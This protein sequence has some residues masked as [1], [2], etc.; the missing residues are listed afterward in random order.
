MNELPPT[1]TLRAFEAAARHSTFTAASA[2]LNVTQSAVSHQILYLEELWGM[3]LF[4]RGR[5]LKLTTEGDALAPIIRQFLVSLDATLAGLRRQRD[6]HPLRISLT[7]SF[8]SRWP[9]PRLPSIEASQPN[10]Q[11]WIET[12]D[13]P[14]GFGQGDADIA[15]RLGTGQYP[16]LFAELLLREYIFPVASKQLLD[17]LGMPNIPADLLHYPLLFRAGPDLV[18]KWEYWFERAGVDVSLAHS[19]TFYPD[20]N[21]TIEAALAGYGIALVRSGHVEKELRDGMLIRLLN[22]RYPSPLAYYFVCPKG[23]ERLPA[24][25]SFKEWIVQEAQQAQSIYDSEQGA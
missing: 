9:L 10:L 12:T 20:T 13:H 5:T 14:I 22:V 15:V 2:E 23:R 8:A 24:I 3:K 1:P 7:Q 18:P 16:G 25:A 17:R 4:E 11:L 6:R 19:G 21:M